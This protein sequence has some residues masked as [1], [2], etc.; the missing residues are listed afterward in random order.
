MKLNK[1]NLTNRLGYTKV[2][3]DWFIKM[4]TMIPVVERE[5]G[6]R[7]VDGRKLHEVLNV[8]SRYNDWINNRI[9]KYG[10]KEDIDYKLATKILVTKKHGGQNA[11][12]YELTVNMAKELS[13]IE[14]NEIG[15]EFRSYFIMAEEIALKVFSWER[16]R[17][18]NV[19][20]HEELV[21]CFKREY[22]TKHGNREPKGWMYGQLQN[23]V[24]WIVFGVD[25]AKEA[26]DYLELHAYESI[27]ANVMEHIDNALTYVYRTMT[28]LIE[29]GMIDEREERSYKVADLFD[30]K[31]GG[32]I[33]LW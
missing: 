15:S 28:L 31:F 4:S 22:M 27:P 1:Q 5:D 29:M 23:D 21:S 12:E 16:E 19:K 17:A 18:D 6:T 9:K 20:A 8:K 14:N 25:N 30:K 24:Y 26:K 3:A 13:M 2:Q 33:K 7:Y 32:I 10:F 11:I